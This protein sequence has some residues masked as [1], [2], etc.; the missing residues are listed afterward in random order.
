MWFAGHWGTLLNTYLLADRGLSNAAN[1]PNYFPQA[2]STCLFLL[3]PRKFPGHMLAHMHG[4]MVCRGS[5]IPYAHLAGR[6]TLKMQNSAEQCCK[7]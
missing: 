3:P 7:P 6:D 2:D 1:H 5:P 4:C